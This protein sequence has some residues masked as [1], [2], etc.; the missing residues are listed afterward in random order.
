MSP[1]FT[2]HFGL[3]YEMTDATTHVEWRW[4]NDISLQAFHAHILV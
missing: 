3:W 1:A 4:G 2:S